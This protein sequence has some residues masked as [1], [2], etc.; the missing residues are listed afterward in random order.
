MKLPKPLDDRIYVERIEKPTR[1][2]LTDRDPTRFAKVL[3]IGPKVYDVNPGD[4]VLLPG[5]AA[6]VPD[7]ERKDKMFI[8]QADIGGIVNAP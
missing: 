3:S 2:V 8:R 4:V 6:S 5:I 7:W 1:I